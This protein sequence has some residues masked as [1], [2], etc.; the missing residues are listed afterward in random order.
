MFLLTLFK[1]SIVEEATDD[2]FDLSSRIKRYFA[3]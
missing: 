2:I 1:G 3:M